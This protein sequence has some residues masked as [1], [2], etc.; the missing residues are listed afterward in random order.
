MLFLCMCSACYQ[1]QGL[2]IDGSS[3]LSS[4]NVLAYN[5]HCASNLKIE[6]VFLCLW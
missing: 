4:L 1:A 5:L 2:Q 6:A 3:S